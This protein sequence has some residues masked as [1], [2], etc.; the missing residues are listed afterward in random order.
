[1]RLSL[2][3]RLGAMMRPQEFNMVFKRNDDGQYCSCAIGAAAEAIGTLP[4]DNNQGLQEAVAAFPLLLEYVMS[5]TPTP[6][7]PY[8]ETVWCII[9]E[10]N[11]SHWT[12]ERIADWVETI[13]PQPVAVEQVEQEDVCQ[14]TTNCS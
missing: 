13:E 7:G 11:N 6:N 5:P 2:A 8:K 12:R 14:A 4:N 9:A 10:L 3:I 1:M